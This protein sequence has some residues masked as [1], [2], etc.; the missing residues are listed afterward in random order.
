MLAKHKIQ[1][2]NTDDDDLA[3]IDTEK[4]ERDLKSKWMDGE[5]EKIRKNAEVIENFTEELNSKIKNFQNEVEVCQDQIKWIDTQDGK[6]LIKDLKAAIET[7]KQ[8]FKARPVRGSFHSDGVHCKDCKCK[9]GS[10]NSIEHKP[11]DPNKF[12]WH[13]NENNV[14]NNRI[15]KEEGDVPNS[16]T[17]RNQKNENDNKKKRR[18]SSLQSIPFHTKVLGDAL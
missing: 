5:Y 9:N 6:L 7:T 14:I 8:E 17:N 2:K 10:H 12:Q 3:E 4:Y 11:F 16:D 18:F 13:C 15:I 1:R